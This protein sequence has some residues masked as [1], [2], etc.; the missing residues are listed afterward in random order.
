MSQ[1]A[2]QD[3]T[4]RISPPPAEKN[5]DGTQ[6]YRVVYEIDVCAAT[7]LDAALQVEAIF[8]D[9]DAMPPIL[10]IIDSEGRRTD[11]DLYHEGLEARGLSD[12]GDETTDSGAAPA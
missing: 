9:P 5:E 1:S 3:K 4:Y 11:V 2:N 8:R 6:S 10:T 12:F 7:P